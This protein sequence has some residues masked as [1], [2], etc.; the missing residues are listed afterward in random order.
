MTYWL[1]QADV[2]GGLFVGGGSSLMRKAYVRKRRRGAVTTPPFVCLPAYTTYPALAPDSARVWFSSLKIKSE[3]E[4]C[5]SP[6]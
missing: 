5:P 2:E 3:A 4:R 6:H 1:E